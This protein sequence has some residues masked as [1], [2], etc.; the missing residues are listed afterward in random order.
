MQR[1]RER[2]REKEKEWIM[3]LTEEPQTGNADGAR[4]QRKYIGKVKVG[5]KNNNK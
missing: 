1:E 4:S 2:K 3:M 5:S